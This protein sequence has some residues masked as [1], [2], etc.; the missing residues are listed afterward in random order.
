MF[1]GRYLRGDALR[2][3]SVSAISLSSPPVLTIYR[4]STFVQRLQMPPSDVTGVFIA[5]VRLGASYPSG[6]YSGTVNRPLV[7]STPDPGPTTNSIQ[8]LQGSLDTFWFEI[9]SGGSADG[10]AESMI[11]YRR[12]HASFLVGR[13]DSGKRFIAKNPAESL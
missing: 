3:Q 2:V 7:P 10:T 9:V 1:F 11:Y 8:A 4:G 13:L 12:P 5:T 6:R